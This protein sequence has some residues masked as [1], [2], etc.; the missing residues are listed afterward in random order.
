MDES[1]T[2]EEKKVVI[3][4]TPVEFET[5]EALARSEDR[6]IRAQARNMIVSELPITRE[7][8]SA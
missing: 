8:T 4:L 1:E 7:V 3:L 5:L 2:V 6:S